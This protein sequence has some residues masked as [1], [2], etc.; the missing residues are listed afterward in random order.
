ME[1]G[2]GRGRETETDIG[3]EPEKLGKRERRMFS[4]LWIL[5]F[6]HLCSVSVKFLHQPDLYRQPPCIIILRYKQVKVMP[7]KTLSDQ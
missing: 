3:R 7:A 4:A 1:R 2:V 5:I 6:L